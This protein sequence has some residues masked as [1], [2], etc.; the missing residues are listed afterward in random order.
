MPQIFISHATADDIIVNRLYDKLTTAGITCWVDHY[1]GITYGDNWSRAI[2]DAA[3]ESDFGLFVMSPRSVKSNYC[4]AEWNRVLALGKRLYI[5]L[6]DDVPVRDVPLRLG[7]IQYV[8]L[9]RDFDATLTGLIDAIQGDRTLAGDT[10]APT[11]KRISGDFPRSQLDLPL[12]GRDAKL[13]EARG[14]IQDRARLTAILGLGGVGKTRLAAEIAASADFTDGVVWHTIKPTST[15]ADLAPTIRDHLK[16][17]RA[18]DDDAIWRELD[19]RAVLMVLDNAEDCAEP[20]AYADRLNALDLAGGT[21]VLMTSRAA[22]PQVR[23]AKGIDLAAPPLREAADIF[24]AM[25]AYEPP[26][27]SPAGQEED[28][29]QA[30]R[31][32]PRLMLYA[33]GWLNTYDPAYVLG[34]LRSLR[35]ADAEQA[36]DQL[37]HKTVEALRTREGDAPIHALRRLAVC[38]GGFTFEAA[39][40]L[41]DEPRP[42]AVLKTWTLISVDQ[43]R[44]RIDP[45][46]IAAAGE[47]DAAHRPHYDYYKA[48]AWKHDK[49]QDYAGLAPEADN[50]EAAFE[51]AMQSDP[52]MALNLANGCGQF[53]SNR[54]E[55][56]RALGWFQR[57]AAALTDHP[58][59]SLW[60]NAQNSLGFAYG[61]LPTGSRRDNLK[62]AV[63][64]CR[65]ALSYRTPGSAPLDYAGTQNNLGLAYWALALV[66]DRAANLNKAVECYR[67]ALVYWTPEA[68][69]LNYAMTQNNL[70]LAYGALALV[71]DRAD[72]LRR[73]VECYREAL[74][75]YTP[76]SAPLDYAM[77]QYNLGLAYQNLAA[78]EDRADNLRRAVECYREALKYYTPDSAPL[79]YAGTQNNLATA[80]KNLSELEDRA[81]NLRRAVECYREALKYHTPEA[82]PLNYAGTQNNLGNAYRNLAALEDRA[83]NLRRAVE[84][85]QNALVHY[86]PEAA[87]L[88]YAM[89]QN[90]L[91]AAYSDLAAVEDR[92]ANL[93]RAVECFQNALVHYTP[94][95][96]PLNYAMTQRNLGIAHKDLGEIDPAI[97]C[98]REAERYYRLM[99]DIENADLMRQWIIDAGGTI[100]EG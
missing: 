14:S 3:N 84:C 6:I 66:E 23:G 38:R 92:A 56:S 85:F 78:L 48:L 25:I 18:A 20:Q 39:R 89:T 10:S 53:W 42:L 97:A 21:R 4:E 43:G 5:A 28:F 49:A 71:E 34:V 17:D 8:D 73:A 45:L 1:K 24:R 19:R 99:E 54:G 82:A 100:D 40:A 80:Y 26:A 13:N 75:Y 74:K 41:I 70:G 30:A 90:N 91:G 68:A 22:W 12:I 69:P 64:C 77:T 93:R 52:E 32:H 11:F 88:A 31:C 9:R 61:S 51:W 35:G 27:F 81:D 46:V 7:T 98:W 79:D 36:L 72:N 16:L 62:K 86:T 37:V 47:D 57:T 60:A 95:A 63:E 96:A 58:D 29:A 33:V 59:K 87:P 2:H 15:P 83:A 55:F 94:E 65:E 44:Y 50:L 67:E 76:D